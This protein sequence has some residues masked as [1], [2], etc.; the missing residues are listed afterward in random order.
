MQSATT[1]GRHKS[2]ARKVI[3][4]YFAFEG[5]WLVPGIAKPEV[6][7]LHVKL[8]DGSEL[9]EEVREGRF[10]IVREVDPIPFEATVLSPDGKAI[11]DFGL[12]PKR[13]K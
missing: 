13:A 6:G 8:G 12:P 4:G 7:R 2:S 10:L 1:T 3:W 5:L 11:D 9:D